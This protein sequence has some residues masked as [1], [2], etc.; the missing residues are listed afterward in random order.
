[1]TAHRLLKAL[2][3]DAPRSGARIGTVICRAGSQAY[4][5]L[6]DGVEYEV[7]AAGDTIAEAGESIAVAMDGK[8][9]TVSVIGPVKRQI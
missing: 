6:I 5:V 1:M 9:R 3:K 2:R 8:G 4:R 7:F